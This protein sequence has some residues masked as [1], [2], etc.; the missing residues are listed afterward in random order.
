[1]AKQAKKTKPIPAPAASE[2]VA[3][4]GAPRV[5][6]I[7]SSVAVGGVKCTAGAIIGPNVEGWPAHRVEAHL[8]DGRAEVVAE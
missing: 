7:V 8:R 6:L 5:R 2:Q 4:M 1:M 3:E